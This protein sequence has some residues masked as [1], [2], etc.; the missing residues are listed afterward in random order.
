MSDREGS[1]RE[2]V[3]GGA[4][5]AVAT[6]IQQASLSNQLPWELWTSFPLT[7]DSPA[8]NMQ[9]LKPEARIHP[10]PV[11]VPGASMGRGMGGRYSVIHQQDYTTTILFRRKEKLERVSS[12]I[13]TH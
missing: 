8:G 11:P 7:L 12:L 1:G 3:E 10:D 9:E 13:S 2:R 5:A 4:S 6:D